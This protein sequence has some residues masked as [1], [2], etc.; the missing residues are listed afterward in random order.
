MEGTAEPPKFERKYKLSS[1]NGIVLDLE[2]DWL[3][4]HG[5]ELKP[6]YVELIEVGAVVINSTNTSDMEYE[7]VIDQLVRPANKDFVSKDFE[8]LTGITNQDVLEE[9]VPLADAMKAFW[10]VA[11]HYDT[12]MFYGS[13]DISILRLAAARTG[14]EIRLPRRIHDIKKGFCQT[15][16]IKSSVSLKRALCMIDADKDGAMHRAASDAI[17]AA[18]VY[19]HAANTRE[20]SLV[21]DSDFK[22]WLASRYP[23]VI[24]RQRALDKAAANKDILATWRKNQSS[25]E[26]PHLQLDSPGKPGQWRPLFDM[27][28][29]LHNQDIQLFEM[30]VFNNNSRNSSDEFR[31]RAAKYGNMRIAQMPSSAS[32]RGL[33]DLAV[34]FE[35][36]DEVIKEIKGRLINSYYSSTAIQLDPILLDGP[37]GVG[38]TEFSRQLAKTLGLPFFEFNISSAH[39]RFEICGGHPGWSSA[40]PG[41]ITKHM[42]TSDY[43][44]PVVLMDEIE[45]ARS[46]QGDNIVQPLL[47]F[48]DREQSKRVKD[49]NL[50]M[51][52]DYSHIFFIATTNELRFVGDAM[53]SRFHIFDIKAPT[54]EQ[55]RKIVRTIYKKLRNERKALYLSESLSSDV[56]MS[57]SAMPPRE[58]RA[59]LSHAINHATLRLSNDGVVT[60]GAVIVSDLPDQGPDKL[61]FG[62]VP[63]GL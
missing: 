17:S 33:D 44:N 1:G 2:W 57:I 25:D 12:W 32:I 31:L 24:R 13:R 42:L 48:L 19:H 4:K 20:I 35:N 50:D 56:V 51:Q 40:E 21:S 10:E 49:N 47:Q 28:E 34:Q 36:F 39:G 54:K 60:E 11:Q 37:P 38:K 14:V 58:I 63:G 29:M 5:N 45:S 8:T 18:R 9:G 22:V 61:S 27:R 52:F 43:L 26:L 3:D 30:N 59:A 6:G 53:K 46:A 41:R 55:T 23:E 62:F 16:K 7:V 15:Y